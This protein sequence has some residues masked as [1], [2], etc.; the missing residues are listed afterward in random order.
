[1][2]MKKLIALLVLVV[3]AS[4]GA[5]AQKI[6]WTNIE[7]ILAYMPETEAMEKTL[8][9]YEE[10]ALEQLEIKQKYYQQKMLEYME[11]KQAGKLTPE[12]D[13]VAQQE[14]TKLQS[15]IQ[16]G[17]QKAEGMIIQQRMKL[18]EPIQTKMQ[19]AIDDVAAEGGY[20]YI[21]NNAMGSGIPSIL[22]GDDSEDVTEKIATKLGIDTEA[23][24]E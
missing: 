16:E 3:V 5:Q 17:I 1:M 20:D 4:L 6:G 19:K 18:L 23:G 15:E 2:T 14:L 21:L 12:M 8:K 10:K 9:T 11:A 13:N 22:F 24:G 7:L